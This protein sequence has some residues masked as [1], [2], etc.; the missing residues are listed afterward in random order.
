MML[1]PPQ[2]VVYRGIVAG[3]R[4]SAAP[5]VGF[6]DALSITPE[7]ANSVKLHE[8]VVV[9]STDSKIST[10]ATAAFVDFGAGTTNL[11]DHL[12]KYLVVKDSTGNMIKGW[13]KAAGS[14][15]SYFN[16]LLAN[17]EFENTT[18]VS[19]FSSATLTS[20]AGGKTNNCLLI[21]RNGV[22]NPGGFESLNTV[23]NG[24]YLA[25]VYA[26]AKEEA[27][28]ALGIYRTSTAQV[29]YKIVTAEAAADWS[30]QL[31]LYYTVPATPQYMII[32]SVAA[33]G[34][35]GTYFDTASVKQV[36]TP[37]ATGVTISSTKN[38][39]AMDNW[40]A[41]NVGGTFNYAD[42]NGY[43]YTIYDR[44]LTSFTD[45]NYQI[46][47]YPSTTPSGRVLKGVLKAVGTS[48]GLSATELITGWTNNTTH[49]YETTGASFGTAGTE[50]TA[51]INTTGYGMAYTN[52]LS[53]TQG[54][55]LKATTTLTLNSGTAPNLSL[56]GT[57]A[58]AAP[59]AKSVLLAAGAN[60]VYY[61]AI[62]GITRLLFI[63]DTGVAT[64]FSTATT[65]F[66]QVTAP[67]SSGSRI[68]SAKGGISYNFSV[69][70]WIAADYNQ[71][72]Y[73]VIIR[74]LRG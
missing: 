5:D 60:A 28:A 22:A 36:I 23:V 12:G 58:G 53:P 40:E 25:S 7:V 68:V 39:T 64:N 72:A 52:T 14:A 17:T 49:P 51:A 46:E 62:T 56:A 41:L 74:K 32:Q 1:L 26:K 47:I 9:A 65:S 10:A 35:N 4:V 18:D 45:G 13:I 73:T 50:I 19:S 15:E 20:V 34:T 27:T 43:T 33:A 42:A 3:L 16:E 29:A 66:K 6:I 37:S 69:N 24:L 30:V 21:A 63:N 57:I 44:D 48:E 70:Q 2:P 54:M 59:N 11:T 71:A 67:S 55:L 31:S 8:N 38:G 61:S